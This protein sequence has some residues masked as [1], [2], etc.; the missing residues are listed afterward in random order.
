MSEFLR[1]LPEGAADVAYK[2]TKMFYP[3]NGNPA[4]K[5]ED[6]AQEILIQINRECAGQLDDPALMWS[7]A[8][9]TAVELRKN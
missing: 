6:F 9:D 1:G 5:P 8:I 4:L 7:V 2:V 3:K